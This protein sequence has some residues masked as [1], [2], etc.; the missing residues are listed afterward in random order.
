MV[1]AVIPLYYCNESLYKTISRCLRALEEHYPDLPLYIVDDASPL[2][3]D[4]P[5]TVRNEE[6]KGFTATVN[7]G[8]RESGFDVACVLNDDV[9][10]TAGQLD[11]LFSID[12]SE[13][14]VWSVQDSAGT[15]DDSFGCC[16]ATTR[17]TLREHGYLNETLKHYFS[18]KEFLGRLKG[19]GVAIH[20]DASIVLEHHES[21]TYSLVNKETLL[22]DDAARYTEIIWS[23]SW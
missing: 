1:G 13:K 20:K 16:W 17:C 10:V 7:R 18:D 2:E 5:I 8:L 14:G 15:S 3:H 23:K 6:N 22:S 4:F 9:F 12:P 19:A 11:W 21:A